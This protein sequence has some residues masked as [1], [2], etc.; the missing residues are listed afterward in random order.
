MRVILDAQTV[1]N[2]GP[3]RQ[4]PLI[5][6][7]ALGGTA[8]SGNFLQEVT[9]E[10]QWRGVGVPLELAASISTARRSYLFVDPGTLAAVSAGNRSTVAPVLSGVLHVRPREGVTVAAGVA[11][12]WLPD[13]DALWFRPLPQGNDRFGPVVGGVA[14]ARW[15]TRRVGVRASAFLPVTGANTIRRST[16]LPARA[17]IAEAGVT[18]ETNRQLQL[19]VLGSNALGNTGALALLGDREYWSLGGG[20]SISPRR[21]TARGDAASP[22][23]DAVAGRL[24]LLAGSAGVSVVT[25]VRLAPQLGMRLFHDATSGTIDESELGGAAEFIVRRRGRDEW[26]ALG[27][28]SHTNNVFV[29]YRSADPLAFATLGLRKRSIRLGREN[30]REGE[31]YLLTAGAGW[32]RRW[33]DRLTTTTQWVATA[34]Q[35]SGWMLSGVTTDARMVM[36][37]SLGEA[38][39]GVPFRDNAHGRSALLRRP[40]WQ[41]GWT[42]PVAPAGVQVTLGN[43]LGESPFHQL[44]A[45]GR[46]ELVVRAGVVL[47]RR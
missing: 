9:G 3:G 2:S 15:S 37:G 36:H 33:S 22:A 46:H 40:V 45:R 38:M 18:W 35:R 13:D 30:E 23:W 26:L 47:V 17:V 43:R 42:W 19:R 24:Q 25:Q 4:G 20:A 12:L 34:G 39:L 29:N 7:R 8:G 41:L 6:K 16:G 21:G 1:D 32:R 28:A 10:L 31:I 11:G 5:A 14:R 27:A 44:R